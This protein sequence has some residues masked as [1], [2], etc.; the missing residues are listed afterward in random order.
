MLTLK[1]ISKKL[2]NFNLSDISIAIPAGTYYVL[3]GRSGSGKTQLLELIAGLSRPDTGEIWL[4]S[5]NITSQRIQH[6]N[7]G[8]VFQDYAVFPNMNVFENIAYSIYSG[9]KNKELV[10]E[11]VLSISSDL[12]IAHLLDRDTKHL[13]GGE[14][15]RV[16]LARTLIK[17]PRLLLLDEPMAS[18]DASL[19]DGIKRLFRRLNRAGLTII[20]VTHDYREAVSLASR[21]G[22]IHGGRIIQEGTPEEVFRKPVN[23]FVA[24]YS[25]IRNFFR[26]KFTETAGEWKALCNGNLIFSL[27]GK[28]FPAGGLL[29]VRSDDIRIS[30]GI[31]RPCSENCFRGKVTDILPSEYGMEVSVDTGVIFYIDISADTFRQ[32]PFSEHSEVWISFPREACIVLHE[33]KLEGT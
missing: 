27:E 24:R 25:G 10:E 20:H 5:E 11:K 15:Q 8:L 7:I 23:K 12:N 31:D 26:V 22:V 33:E 13:S 29:L 3:L 17:S 30:T 6:R 4:G 14:L 32:N 19:K 9:R 21:V 16:A 28:S 1:N 2:G 18:I